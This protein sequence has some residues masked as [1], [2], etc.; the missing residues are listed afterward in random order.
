MKV[1]HSLIT[2]FLTV[3]LLLP[4]QAGAEGSGWTPLPSVP[5][6]VKGEQC[7]E[8]TDL[9]RKKHFELLKHQ[10]DDT[11]RKGIR[12]KKHS[13]NECLTCHVDPASNP[14]EDGHFCKNCHEYAAVSIDCFQCHNTKPQVK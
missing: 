5:K 4:L 14:K 11:M 7:V 2:L 12:T 13:L 3:C 8:D 6:A 10:R 9:M 1:T